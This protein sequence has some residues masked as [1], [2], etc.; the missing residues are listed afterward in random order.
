[1]KWRN[2]KLILHCKRKTAMDFEI[3]SKREY[4]SLVDNNGVEL[5][6]ECTFRLRYCIRRK[7]RIK[8]EKCFSTFQEAKTY[9]NEILEAAK[10]GSAQKTK[11]R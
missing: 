2:I 11:L 1:M 8:P 4:F 7:G 5:N 6:N 10:I 3:I 9:L